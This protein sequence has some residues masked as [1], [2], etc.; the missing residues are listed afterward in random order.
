MKILINFEKKTLGYTPKTARAICL[1]TVL[2][3]VI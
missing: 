2:E 1:Q 3:G